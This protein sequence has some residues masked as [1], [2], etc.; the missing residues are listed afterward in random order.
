MSWLEGIWGWISANGQA[1]EGIGSIGALAIIFL[2]ARQIADAAANQDVSTALQ[3]VRSFEDDLTRWSDGEI[4]KREKQLGRLVGSIEVAAALAN[5]K[6]LPKATKYF[7][8]HLIKDALSLVVDASDSGVVLRDWMNDAEVCREV[9]LYL[10]ENYS[11]VRQRS[12]YS[13]IYATFFVGRSVLVE[14][15]TGIWASVS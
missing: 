5:F 7:V 8:T 14:W 15:D 6:R 2:T 4:G 9:R 10:I 12:N 11:L 1:L 13:Q 3:F